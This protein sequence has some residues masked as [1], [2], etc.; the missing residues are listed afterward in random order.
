MIT[1]YTYDDKTGEYRF[2]FKGI[3]A[4]EMGNTLKCTLRADSGNLSYVSEEKTFSVKQ[5][6]KKI[7]ELKAGST[8]ESDQLLCTL[9]VDM[10]NYGAAA[11][12]HFGKN[13]G[14]LANSE[15]TAA[16]KNMASPLVTEM[17]STL[18]LDAYPNTS[19]K[20]TGASLVFKNTTDFV[21]YVSMT[22]APGSNV[23][24]EV[25]YTGCNG[26]T[27]T[28]RVSSKDFKKV[29]DEYRIAF[30]DISALYFRTPIHVVFMD[31]ENTISPTLTYSYETYAQE[32]LSGSTY[33]QTMKELVKYLITYGDSALEYFKCKNG[34]SEGPT[35][36]VTYSMFKEADDPDDY[37][38]LV[39]AHAYA[40]EHNLPVKAD[41][42]AKY[43]INHMDPNTMQRSY[44]AIDLK[45]FYASV[46]CVQR[47][48]DP[49][50]TNLVVADPTRTEKTICLAV[51]PS[52]KSY[53]I[54]GRARLFE[55]IQK[56]EQVNQERK[57]RAPGGSL[58]GKSTF[59]TE[60]NTNPSL[61]VDF[62][63]ASPQ[64]AKY[65]QVSAKIYETYLKYVAPEDIFAYSVDEVFIDA[66]GYLKTY[67]V[68]AHDFARMLIQDVLK[69]TGI[70]ATAG[71]G[72]NM[73]LCKVAMD[74]EA[75]HIPADKDG[76]RI[77]ELDE[78]KYRRSL[79]DHR[80][81]TDFW[82]VGRG[83][84]A[85]LEK[86]GMR[87]MGDIARCSLDRKT[88]GL[89]YQT[90]GKNAELLIDHAWR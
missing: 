16:Q 33:S 36:Y 1:D 85:R 47:G 53:G 12:L 59:G 81:L 30:S 56:V 40:N 84:A 6:A 87:T 25:Y 49:L 76:V 29:E 27:L 23:Y 34:G 13:T 24:A 26:N 28:S 55:V 65:M 42:G 75:K 70:T 11:Q 4:S 22:S 44:I 78:M 68:E 10:L 18:A 54:P 3:A 48:L 7:L 57:C 9:V 50:N 19:V 51:S 86:L 38:S 8:V 67:E 77:A 31:G 52:L 61:A 72:T 80:P 79:W 63:I 41:P 62:I 89:L 20:F 35:T 82:R 83:I 73:Y 69:S 21:T 39:R 43:V 90:F 2:V 17:N 60:L 14:S 15:L 37:M 58:T 45:S 64:M 66:T 32:I 5:Y 46:E 71:I 88:I 74:I